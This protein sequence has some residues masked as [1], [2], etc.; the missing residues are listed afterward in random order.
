MI[1][2]LFG[3]GTI[4]HQLRQGLDELSVRHQGIADRVANAL[5]V[6][7]STTDFAEELAEAQAAAQEA[8]LQEDMVT[9][10][11][12]QIRYDADTRLLQDAYA[13]LRTAINDRA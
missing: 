3:P 10:A 1:K 9:L 8:E 4:T 11:D 7:S 6:S 13:R 2:G 12:N 5:R